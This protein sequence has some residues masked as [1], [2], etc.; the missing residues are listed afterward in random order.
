MI[1]G[2]R[3][4]STARE[5]ERLR[6][7]YRIRQRVW[8]AEGRG[9][10]ELK[11]V[12]DNCSR[13]EGDKLSDTTATTTASVPV[14]DVESK[15]VTTRY[16]IY[17]QRGDRSKFSL[18]CMDRHFAILSARHPT[19]YILD[20]PTVRSQTLHLS[21]A[22]S[23]QDYSC[24]LERYIESLSTFTI[25]EYATW[26]GKFS[27]VSS[28]LVGGVNPCIRGY[29]NID[30]KFHSENV[31]TAGNRMEEVGS[32]VMKRFFDSFPGRL[33]TYIVKRAVELRRDA[34][35]YLES[36][37]TTDVGLIQCSKCNQF[38]T[39]SSQLKFSQCGHNFCEVCFWKDILREI[40]SSSRTSL[41]DVVLCPVCGVS[42]AAELVCMVHGS[43]SELAS[44]EV[45]SQ[46]GME[47]LSP[48]QRYQ[49]SLHRLLELPASTEAIKITGK[50]KKKVTDV[51]H[52][53]SSWQKAVIPL[54]GLTQDVRRDK[55]SS[56]VDRNAL[57][58]IR[59]CLQE[60]VDVNY[61][62]EYGQTALFIA[63][64]RGYK[65]MVELL[66]RYG[67]DPSIT[68]YG[69]SSVWS[70]CAARG[71]EDIMGLLAGHT[72]LNGFCGSHK[73]CLELLQQSVS[74]GGE[75]ETLISECSDHPGRGSV[76]IDDLLSTDAVDL[77]L[78]LYRSLPVDTNQR[79][80][81]NSMVCSDRSY[82]CDAEGVLQKLLLDGLSRVGFP[83]PDELSDST[84]GDVTSP[85]QSV[86]HIFPHMRFLNYSRPGGVLPPHVDLCRVDPFCM[87]GQKRSTHTFILYLTDCRLGGETRLLEDMS[88]EG[89]PRATITPRRGRLLIFPHSTPHEGLEVVDIP[90]I[91]LRGEIRLSSFEDT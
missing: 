48:S 89:H 73:S 59:G 14:E 51:E 81:K 8:S 69:G 25:M 79:Q 35:V 40:D 2:K 55:F 90:K 56:Y 21:L 5:R 10:D 68:A 47:D 64:W 16:L 74:T 76:L 72:P 34:A 91:L 36:C 67:A 4:W 50:K 33:S 52:L 22:W 26:M 63:V 7:R 29:H 85:S 84:P 13:G 20:D 58:F 19:S 75:V 49:A 42:V 45:C 88:G 38:S 57:P 44:L 15:A 3:G 12:N 31:L 60:G 32:A 23:G 66:L 83:V 46:K 9:D 54:L 61:R 11:N 65:D 62:N 87:D 43:T 71:D 80:K 18:A 27:I 77:L 30:Y 39:V 6:A 17:V 70:V 1:E 37:T 41:H 53:A 28:L 24:N 78:R 82:Y 86:T